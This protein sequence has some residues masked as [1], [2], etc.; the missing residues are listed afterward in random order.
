MTVLI[1]CNALSKSHSHNV[2]FDGLTFAIHRGERIG[3]IGPNGSGKST[4]L[5]ILAGIEPPDKGEVVQRQSIRVGYV[6]QTSEYPD[7]DV[8]TLV[9]DSLRSSHLFHHHE[10]REL[11][12]QV[13][14]SKMGFEDYSQIAS[15]LSGGWKKRLD[16]ARALVVEPDL[17][18]L[19]E[20]TNH[21]DIASI[22]WLED[23]LLRTKCTFV[24]VSHDRLFLER[25]TNHIFELN[26]AFPKG[27]FVV[28][29]NYADFLDRR[30]DFLTSLQQYEQ[31]LKSKVRN[32]VAWLK[33]SPKART[34][35]QQA[36]INQARDLEEELQTLRQAKPRPKEDWQ[37]D[38]A[39]LQSRKLC[40]AK[41]L[42]KSIDG[43]WLFKGL[44]VQLSPGSRIGLAGDNGTGKT[45]LLRM[46]AGE[47]T[48]DMGTIKYAEGV[49]IVYFDQHREKLPDQ[50]TL[51]Q[52]LAPNGDMVEYR[53]KMIHVNGW[54]KR[55]H[56]NQD[57]MLMPVSELSGGERARILLAR[58]MLQPGDILLLDEPTND[59]DIETLEVLEES[60]MDFPGAI[61][62]ITH[63][64]RMLDNV[65][66]QIIGLGC[67]EGNYY[68]AD[69]DQWERAKA[70]QK[71]KEVK[72]LEKTSL[73]QAPSKAVPKARLSYHEQQ[74][75]NKME[76]KIS[77]LEQ[78]IFELEGKAQQQ[79]DPKELEKICHELALQHHALDRHY[80]RWQ[81][82][83]SKKGLVT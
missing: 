73:P 37:F 61:V 14:L 58:L 43:K 45:T 55:F 76:E 69:V 5:K 3:I 40:I 10:E 82:L 70:E 57:R 39:G 33:Q 74:E 27:I 9:V 23:L 65:S 20:P 79:Q 52:C 50:Y 72:P 6:P 59:L 24:V 41:N 25:T 38:S 62:L 63:D 42:G 32:E 78:S 64:R 51:K 8:Q 19:D 68:F 36:R 7:I 31:G 35:K 11:A 28:E 17:L 83:E 44:D 2:L 15:K 77:A 60:L 29:G 21:L 16:L 80:Q 12:A 56:F 34:T 66:T 13:I 67:G 75:L 18:L 48:P 54:A 81:E 1:S 22:V 4:L 71:K 26:K 30:S 46:L 47:Q 53:G 49:R